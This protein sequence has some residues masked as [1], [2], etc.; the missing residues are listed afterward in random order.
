MEEEASATGALFNGFASKVAA[1]LA[2]E[3]HRRFDGADPERLRR[4]AVLAAQLGL[5]R[6][7]WFYDL[8]DLEDTLAEWSSWQAVKAMPEAADLSYPGLIERLAPL[9]P[10]AA[11][12][13]VAA[14]GIEA[15][16]EWW[17]LGATPDDAE[18][19]LGEVAGGFPD[20]AALDPT[21][22]GIVED[23]EADPFLAAWAG[24]R[25][26][27]GILQRAAR[28]HA[29]RTAGV[30]TRWRWRLRALARCVAS[31]DR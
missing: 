16:T 22:V 5:E 30:V 20:L 6:L 15:A 3:L 2:D 14:V 9:D 4:L 10:G 29:W 24:P 12:Q 26:R 18:R 13:W 7:D 23:L 11:R 28:A 27:D 17:R 19:A 31:G 21:T 8:D 1:D 25:L